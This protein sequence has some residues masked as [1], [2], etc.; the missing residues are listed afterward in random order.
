VAVLKLL[1]S[2]EQVDRVA[3]VQVQMVVA[4]PEQ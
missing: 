2:A 4:H 1:V 3:A